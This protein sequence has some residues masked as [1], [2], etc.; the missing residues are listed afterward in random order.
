MSLVNRILAESLTTAVCLPS[1]L[2]ASLALLTTANGTAQIP[3]RPQ[4]LQR[5]GPRDPI[6]HYPLWYEDTNGLRL[7]ICRDPNSCF[8]APPN[9]ALPVSYPDNWPDESFYY[10]MN[11]VMIGANNCKATFVTA[12]EAA[13]DGGGPLQQFAEIVFSRVRIVVTPGTIGLRADNLYQFDHPYGTEQLTSS[14]N[15]DAAGNPTG[16]GDF[17]RPGFTRD[18]MGAVADFNPAMSG[19]VGPFWVPTPFNGGPNGS[20]LN[21]ALAL[22]T[23]KSSGAK[24]IVNGHPYFRITDLGPIETDAAGVAVSS[25]QQEFTTALGYTQGRD[26]QGHPYVQYNLFTIQ[27]QIPTVIGVSL[28]SADYSLGAGNNAVNIW[29]N[30]AASQSLSADLGT[31]GIIPL[32]EDLTHRGSYYGR[33]DIPGISPS[34]AP[35]TCILRNNTDVPPSNTGAVGLPIT[36]LVTIQTAI[37]TGG[38]F[39]VKASSSDK[40]NNT[41]SLVSSVGQGDQSIGTLTAAG[42]AIFAQ[43]TLSAP[44]MEVFVRSNMGGSAKVGVS[45]GDVLVVDPVVANAGLDQTVNDLTNGIPTVVQLSGGLSSGGG[46]LTFAWTQTAGPTATL[47]SASISNPTFSVPPVTL[48]TTILT[49]SLVARDV[50]NNLVNSD[51]VSIT[52]NKTTVVDPTDTIRII[53]ARETNTGRWSANGT[54][55]K[56]NNQTVTIYLDNPALSLSPR[57]IGTAIVN[58]TG[59]WSYANNNNNNALEVARNAIVTIYAKSSNALSTTATLQVTGG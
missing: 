29:A 20:F 36:D 14:V 7:N 49:F 6:T 43:R 8:F 57:V 24:P 53:T 32:V 34:A 31:A 33:Y 39:I 45:I 37:F 44:P 17:R 23:I 52:V 9:P 4:L 21:A 28:N 15:V 19:D 13:Y 40:V 10:G 16:F 18:I 27:G 1:L 58:A 48:A 51:T 55:S 50:I 41:V 35:K 46:T 42:S 5:C 22:T 25:L 56:L 3:A 59:A 12:L 11:C 30:S 26:A 54:A 2:C 47:S 38:Q